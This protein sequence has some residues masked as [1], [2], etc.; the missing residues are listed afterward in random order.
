M[1]LVNKNIR[2][3]TAHA[4]KNIRDSMMGESQPEL[5]GPSS[6][7]LA[8]IITLST[9]L[10]MGPEDWSSGGTTHCVTQQVSFIRENGTQ[11]EALR[12]KTLASQPSTHI[13]P[14]GKFCLKSFS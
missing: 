13:P 3:L 6:V 8:R 12:V 2:G 10:T 11:Q 14:D 7:G 4:N 5:R 1:V 9:E